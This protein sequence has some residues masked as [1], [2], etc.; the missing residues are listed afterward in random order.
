LSVVSVGNPLTPSFFGSAFTETDESDEEQNEK[1]KD[2]NVTTESNPYIN[3]D[4][5]NKLESNEYLDTW[6]TLR[7][8][9]GARTNNFLYIDWSKIMYGVAFYFLI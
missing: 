6:L 8:E 7:E 5:N 4:L 3:A 9:N 1:E 2:K